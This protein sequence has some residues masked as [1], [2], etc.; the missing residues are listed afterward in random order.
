MVTFAY[1]VEPSRKHI[2]VLSR[3]G[4]SHEK[5]SSRARVSRML[6]W[7]RDFSQ[8][9]AQYFGAS[10]KATEYPGLLSGL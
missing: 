6:Q 3:E 9:V 4:L 2:S 7:L 1:S 5:I 10:R 8:V